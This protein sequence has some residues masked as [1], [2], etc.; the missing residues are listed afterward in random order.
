MT[1]PNAIPV[2]PY[3]AGKPLGDDTFAGRTDIL[4]YVEQEL[5]TASR[6]A[7]VLSGQRRIGKTS[8]LLQLQRRLPTDQFLTV[9]FDLQH[10]AKKPLG[11]LLSEL[12]TSAAAKAGFALDDAAIFDDEGKYFQ[13]TF[14]PQLYG[15]LP[16]SQ[17]PVILFDEFDVLDPLTE[18]NLTPNSAARTFHPYLQ[19]LM[20]R[21][22]RLGF[23]FVVGR[24]VEELSIA[25]LNLFRTDSALKRVSVLDK[26]SAED[27]IR[28]AERQGT[29]Y[30]EPDAVQRIWTLTAGHPFLTQLL[31]QEIWNS[32]YACS[33][34]Q[35][36][37]VSIAAVD[38]VVPKAFDRG[39]HIFEWIWAGL[40]PAEQIIL[41]AIA[42]ATTEQTGLKCDDRLLL[43]G[44]HRIRMMA[45][46]LHQAPEKLIEYQHLRKNSEGHYCFLVELLRGWI[47]QHKPLAHIKDSVDRIDKQANRLFET[48]RDYY[49][50]GSLTESEDQL[51]RALDINP[52][53]FQARLLLA[54][55]L[56]EQGLHSESVAQFEVAYKFDEGETKYYLIRALEA[57]S[58]TLEEA[59][60]TEAALRCYQRILEI[61]SVEIEAQERYSAILAAQ[62]D[63]ALAAGELEQ[64][65]A[66]YERAQLP[67]KVKELESALKQRRIKTLSGVAEEL[68][69]KEQW[70]QAAQL[71]EQILDL[72]D[73]GGW[74]KSLLS[75][76]QQLMLKERYDESLR[77]CDR[78]DWPLALGLLAEIAQVRPDYR[79]V[80]KLLVTAADGLARAQG[81]PGLFEAQERLQKLTA[82]RDT[83]KD[84]SHKLGLTLAVLKTSH[85]DALA[86]RDELRV[87]RDELQA[88][89]RKLAAEHQELLSVHS[90][91]REDRDKKRHA[92]SD[93]QAEL[94]RARADLEEA[95]RQTQVID[96][97]FQLARA[98]WTK[99]RRLGYGLA[100]TLLATGGL[101]AAVV[102]P[103]HKSLPPDNAP[104]APPTCVVP[105]LG[106]AVPK[107]LDLATEEPMPH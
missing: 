59:N 86:E 62:G 17:R 83:L 106:I 23:V 52:S 21:E 70:K 35:P 97:S 20:E 27:I 41:A 2:N 53:H 30:F 61:S 89:Q 55:V 51:R 82:E 67:E 14:L 79:G 45:G 63:A 25:V 76:Q 4:S 5:S 100:V 6:S 66:L 46:E 47:V 92:L 85:S 105:D 12:A 44:Q 107:P 91:S 103:S 73:A 102:R 29:L 95:T 93:C 38:S 43:L 96:Q 77:V 81:E 48:G 34:A 31:C 58:R 19:L 72:E 16:H 3:I 33:P 94:A 9:R 22:P 74:E 1:P 75:C 80:A 42:E 60:E 65:Q 39:G 36:P 99:W 87:A 13:Q 69:R 56:S 104:V 71:Y 18:D 78:G 98:N 8:I 15:V 101:G 32:A 7:V 26:S 84:Q 57:Q 11:K 10:Y 40:P 50:S 54:K 88:A 28:I 68:E 37:V 64:A 90:Q 24:K 49:R